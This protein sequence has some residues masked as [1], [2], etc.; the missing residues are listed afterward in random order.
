MTL[1]H[2]SQFEHALIEFGRAISLYPA[3]LASECWYHK[4]N[5]LLS[6]NR[7]E[8]SLA[9]FET[10]LNNMPEDKSLLVKIHYGKGLAYERLEQID[11]LEA[12]S[13]CL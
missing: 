9:A 8:E 12:F 7:L 13:R 11:A 10:A 6:L 5:T 2:S 3:A 4:G 1:F